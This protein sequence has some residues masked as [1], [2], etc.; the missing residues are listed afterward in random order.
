MLSGVHVSEPLQTTRSEVIV[1]D[2]G[3]RLKAFRIG[4]GLSPEELAHKIGIS[5]SAIYRY[6]AGHPPKIEILARFANLLDMSL[7]NLLGVGAEYIS[8]AVAYFERMHQ[9]EEGV[10]QIRVLF[11]PVS[12]LLT[13]DAYDR[14]LPEMLAESVPLDAPDRERTLKEVGTLMSTLLS[15]KEQY[16]R[17]NPAILSLVSMAELQQILRLGLIG[18]YRPPDADLPAR[19]EAA[20]A[21]IRNIAQLLREPPIGVQVGLLIDSMPGASFQVFRHA[22]SGGGR[23]S[24]A[25]SPFRLGL[26]AN[27]RLGVATITSAPEA[28]R[29]Y[30]EM[31]DALWAR[32]LKGD[33]AADLVDQEVSSR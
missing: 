30:D 21:E 10:D 7:A 11:G 23:T 26:Y 4:C 16:R 18:S 25:V 28:V 32:S 27:I 5:R 20:V 22:S 31:T 8:S 29:R 15:R 2:I 6:E 24:V 17:R 1:E 19:R 9:L 3:K 14:I 13:T 12:Y 33:R